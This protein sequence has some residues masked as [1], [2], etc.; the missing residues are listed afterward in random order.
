M[1]RGFPRVGFARTLASAG[2]CIAATRRSEPSIVV[3]S[4]EERVVATVVARVD[5][6]NDWAG[7]PI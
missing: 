6:E 1:V 5:D 2:S 4:W 3:A 7:F